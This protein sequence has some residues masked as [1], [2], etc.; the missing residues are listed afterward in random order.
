MLKLNDLAWIIGG[1]LSI[2]YVNRAIN[3]Y[4]Q[5]YLPGAPGPSI[6]PRRTPLVLHPLPERNSPDYW[7][8]YFHCS[9]AQELAD[10]FEKHPTLISIIPKRERKVALD[11]ARP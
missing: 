6:P 8:A 1:G 5:A 11:S 10:Y 7:R 9:S 3:G 2:R 4:G